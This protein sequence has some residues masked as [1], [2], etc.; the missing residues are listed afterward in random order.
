MAYAYLKRSLSLLTHAAQELWHTKN[1]PNAR[2]KKKTLLTK[3]KHATKTLLT[4]AEQEL[5][6]KAPPIGRVSTIFGEKIKVQTSRR[7]LK[8]MVCLACFC[9]CIIVILGV[10]HVI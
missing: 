2:K 5:W 6:Q 8:T 7:L 9:T 1:A 3:E 4:H 10:L